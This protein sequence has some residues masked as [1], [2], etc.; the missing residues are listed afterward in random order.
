MG[1]QADRSRRMSALGREGH[2]GADRTR[3]PTDY[4]APRVDRVVSPE[5]LEREILYAGG[6]APAPG[7]SS[8]V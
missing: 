4:E 2:E 8:V 7:P 6:P 1:R 5:D 3:V